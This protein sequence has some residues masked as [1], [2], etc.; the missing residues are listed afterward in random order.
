MTG[1]GTTNTDLTLARDFPFHE[2]RMLTLRLEGYNALNHTQFSG[3]DTTL[4]FNN[5]TGEM[6][7]TLFNKPTSARAARRVQVTLRFRF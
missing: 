2:G 3:V 1:P 6:Y 4:R 5:A 7:N